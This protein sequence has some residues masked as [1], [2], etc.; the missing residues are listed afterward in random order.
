MDLRHTRTF[1]TVAELGT[2]SKASL[3]LRI[4]QPALSR[5]IGALEQELGLKLF[6][7]VGRRLIL[8]SEGEQLLSD[9]RGL[10]NHAAAIDERAQ[11]LKRGDTGTLKVAAS[12]QHIESVLSQFL[13]RY[14]Q[15]YPNVQV[16]LIEAPGLEIRAMLERGEVHL[17]QNLLN[18]SPTSDERFGSQ[19]LEYVD[20]LAACHVRLQLG[21]EGKVNIEDLASYPLLLMD[22]QFAVR[23]SFDAACRLAGLKPNIL[24]ESRTP[25]TLLA[26]AEA[27]HGVA[28]IP[29]QLQSHRYQLRVVGVTYRGRLVREPMMIWWDKRRPQPRYAMAFCKMLAEHVREVFPISR[30]SELKTNAKVKRATARRAREY[31]TV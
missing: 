1:V 7:R 18:A 23:G 3:R 22:T 17:G 26:L 5:Q 30:P 25:H 4:A 24:L 31:G 19:P 16:K 21:R 8:T 27:G 15:R 12:P 11:G 9:C 20:I 2:V 28:I 29:S 13:H 14:A 6:D 10:L